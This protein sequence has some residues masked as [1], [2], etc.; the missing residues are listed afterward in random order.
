V[1]PSRWDRLA[2][3]VHEVG[4]WVLYVLALFALVFVWSIMTGDAAPGCVEQMGPC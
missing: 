4:P 2:D 3:L 1:R